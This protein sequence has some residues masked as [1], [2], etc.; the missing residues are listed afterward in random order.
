VSMS[1]DFFLQANRIARFVSF[2]LIFLIVQFVIVFYLYNSYTLLVYFVS[3][4]IFVM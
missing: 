2:F 3:L 1:K 4:V